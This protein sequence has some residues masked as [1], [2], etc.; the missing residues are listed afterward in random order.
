LIKKNEILLKKGIK[1]FQI[2]EKT[3]DKIILI[4]K[5]PLSAFKINNNC[6]YD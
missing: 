2:L 5:Q 6:F 3:S 1:K 4:K